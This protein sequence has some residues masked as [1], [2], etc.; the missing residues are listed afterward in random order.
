MALFSEALFL[1]LF[2]VFSSPRVI[3]S[4]MMHSAHASSIT[5]FQVSGFGEKFSSL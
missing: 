2:P 4:V 3:S 5:T 1:I